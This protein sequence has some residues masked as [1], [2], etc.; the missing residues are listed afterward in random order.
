M[1]FTERKYFCDSCRGIRRLVSR[2]I[3]FA[4]NHCPKCKGKGYLTNED[5]HEP[6]VEKKIEFFGK[7]FHVE[8]EKPEVKK[9]GRPKKL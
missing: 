2:E 3:P 9:R 8:F 1:N 4:L 6:P 5:L 7:N